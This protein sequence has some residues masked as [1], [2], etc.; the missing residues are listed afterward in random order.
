MYPH[1]HSHKH[2]Q[3]YTPWHSSS[4]TH[5]FFLKIWEKQILSPTTWNMEIHNMVPTFAT[6][7]SFFFFFWDF[8]PKQ[9]NRRVHIVW[10]GK[11]QNGANSSQDFQSAQ[12]LC[13]VCNLSPA[14]FK[15]YRQL[16]HKFIQIESGRRIVV[17]DEFEKNR[18]DAI[19][20][21]YIYM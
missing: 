17:L 16:F 5:R 14:T 18:L 20:D 11:S 19:V 21:F 2:T 3:Q 4:C 8:T 6:I 9:N 1:T 10:R 12:R 13:V 15:V 7:F